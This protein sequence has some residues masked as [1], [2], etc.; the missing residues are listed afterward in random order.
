MNLTG[1]ILPSL[2]TTFSE[3]QMVQ[4]EYPSSASGGISEPLGAVGSYI[5]SH[6]AERRRG[7]QRETIVVIGTDL[8]F[9]E[10]RRMV[11]SEQAGDN[12][13]KWIREKSECNVGLMRSN[14]L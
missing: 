14:Q 6:L 4:V 8:H 9:W 3:S 10:S 5:G 13:G 1:Q 7:R 12:P 11:R 2:C